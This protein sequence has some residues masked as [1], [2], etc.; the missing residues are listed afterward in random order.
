MGG[1]LRLYA[2]QLAVL[3]QKTFLLAV[4]NWKQS[5][6]QILAPLLIVLLLLAF[7]GLAN[8]VL[9]R[10]NP[11]PPTTEVG[12]FPRCWDRN[13]RSKAED[14][15]TEC[16][17]VVYAPKGVAWVE[18]LMRTV[19]LDN[20]LDFDRDFVAMQAPGSSLNFFADNSTI[21]NYIIDNPNT[22]Q[23]AIIFQSAYSFTGGTPNPKIPPEP[24]YILF[25]NVT[26]AKSNNNDSPA[27]HFVKSLDRAIL[28][29]QSNLTNVTLDVNYRSYPRAKTRISQYDVVASDGGVWFYVPPMVIFFIL[30]TEV[31]T[32]KEQ[33]LRLGMRMMGMKDSVYWLVWIMNGFIFQVLSTLV[34]IVSGSAAQFK[35]FTN[36]DFGVL[37]VMFLCF[38]LAI[39]R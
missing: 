9:S 16:K 3:T 37:F 6:G 31:V 12:N 11:H 36:A 18:Q 28:L 32:E 1:G 38:G 26:E 14:Y 19:A 7:Q 22:T 27:I 29:Q 35:F 13:T 30:L 21:Y 24:G 25:Y 2:T 39:Q 5:L 10:D 4:R 15:G 8:L 34:L 20:S 17:S 23:I 33:R